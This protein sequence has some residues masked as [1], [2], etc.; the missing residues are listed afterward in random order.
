M[1]KL[2]LSSLK[3]QN[4]NAFV[5]APSVIQEVAEVI[6]EVAPIEVVSP[7]TRPKLSLSAIKNPGSTLSVKPITESTTPVVEEIPASS[8]SEV[9]AVSGGGLKKEYFPNLSV[10]EDI[11][12]D[13]LGTNSQNST[14][15]EPEALDEPALDSEIPELPLIQEEMVSMWETPFIELSLSEV[16]VE[17]LPVVEKQSV[18]AG[19]P[20]NY[21][22][23]V[24]KG[25]SKERKGGLSEFF[26][27]KKVV[28]VSIGWIMCILW[29]VGSLFGFGIIGASKANVQEIP[30]PVTAV[31]ADTSKTKASPVPVEIPKPA[32]VI[33]PVEIPKPVE[34]PVNPPT[35][36]LPTNSGATASE[37]TATGSISTE[38]TSTGVTTSPNMPLR[39]PNIRTLR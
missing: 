12:K 5:D 17:V 38:M 16:E 10:N 32:E 4:P 34:L 3:K 6:E 14:P 28:V 33:P 23:E 1:T 18:D 35:L 13:I 19:I 27:K 15:I 7:N 11:F 8:E 36:A 30:K 26:A 20:E 29:V 39:T 24:A 9:V 2:N 31:I 25:L 22:Q 37:T 21:V